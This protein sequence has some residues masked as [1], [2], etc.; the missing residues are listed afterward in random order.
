VANIHSSSIDVRAGLNGIRWQRY[1]KQRLKNLHPIG[2][3][4]TVKKTD[5]YQD[6]QLQEANIITMLNVV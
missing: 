1:P 4:N 3:M 2:I 6:T 5:A